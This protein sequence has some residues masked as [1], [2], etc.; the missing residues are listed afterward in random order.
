M[1]NL[2]WIAVVVTA[3]SVWLTG[4]RLV[5]CWPIGLLSVALYGVVFFQARLYSDVLLQ[6]AFALF[7][8]YG[9]WYW[10]RHGRFES[11]PAS[12]PK[13][14]PMLAPRAFRDLASGAVGAGLLGWWMAGH[15]DA[16]LPWVDATL[17]AFSLVAQ[18][19][20]A[21]LYR[22]NW[23]LWIGVD[24]AYVAVYA[25]R[26]LYPTAALYGAFIALAAYGWRRW[27]PAHA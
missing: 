5:W 25:Q 19:W 18:F 23:L 11:A 7:Q 24:V 8:A 17:T 2:E 14:Q 26:G 20:M 10:L 13:I 1:D 3:I 16:A 4:R 27:T 21:R 6:L 15:T 22:A 9:W 12:K